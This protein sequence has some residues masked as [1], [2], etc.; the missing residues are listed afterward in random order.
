MGRGAGR[1]RGRGHIADTEGRGGDDGGTAA[2]VQD[3]VAEGA[4][5]EKEKIP[6][7][8]SKCIN[9]QRKGS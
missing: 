1:G 5:L 8:F 3:A 2:A 9:M 7:A 6:F 4:A